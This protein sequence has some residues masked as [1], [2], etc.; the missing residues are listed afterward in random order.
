[1][2]G[3]TCLAPDRLGASQVE[4]SKFYF[5]PGRFFYRW[6]SVS[7]GTGEKSNAVAYTDFDLSLD[8]KS[9][10]FSKRLNTAIN[11]GG[12]LIAL[13]TI[14]GDIFLRKK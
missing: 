2:I 10:A 1:M 12:P 11:G 4:G 14:S 5:R 13:E 3:R 7:A 9:T 6:L 8:K